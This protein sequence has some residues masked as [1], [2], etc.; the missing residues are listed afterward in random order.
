METKEIVITEELKKK[1]SG[2]LGFQVETD[3]QYTPKI[4]KDVPRELW[5]T[6]TL[7]SKNGLDMADI[8]D[9]TGYIEYDTKDSTKSKLVMQSGKVRVDTLRKGLVKVENFITEN[10]TVI[11]FDCSKQPVDN[12]IKMLPT[13]L[14]VELQE[15]INER[16][17]LS[18]DEKLGLES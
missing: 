17:V 18:S 15:A 11:S 8:E 13:R 10:G 12:L 7:K 5:P 14:Q 4:F 2:Y 6:F 9:K 3:F 1:L 16:N